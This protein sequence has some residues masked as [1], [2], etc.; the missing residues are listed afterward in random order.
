MYSRYFKDI[1]PN[2]KESDAHSLR[3]GWIKI[4]KNVTSTALV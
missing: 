3:G 4:L 1:L 2:Y